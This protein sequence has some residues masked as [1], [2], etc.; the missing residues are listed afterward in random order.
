MASGRSWW[1]G[2]LRVCVPRSSSSP[3]P[4]AWVSGSASR[5][6]YRVRCDECGGEGLL[7]RHTVSWS[8]PR[9]DEPAVF[10]QDLRQKLTLP[11]AHL[12]ELGDGS[13]PRVFLLVP[14]E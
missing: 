12:A 2:T 5:P 13:A 11:Y 10:A 6:P 14:P 9:A 3:A 4:R 1:A 8:C 7:P